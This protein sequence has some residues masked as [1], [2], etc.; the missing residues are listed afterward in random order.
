MT[1][2][3][4]QN[5]E[6]AAQLRAAKRDEEERFREMEALDREIQTLRA[7]V[8]NDKDVTRNKVILSVPANK[9]NADEKRVADYPKER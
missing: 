9:P 2:L 5:I 4:Q 3:R 6:L 8:G 7:S 1:H